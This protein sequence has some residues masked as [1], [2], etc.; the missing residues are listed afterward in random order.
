M[1]LA[2]TTQSPQ[3]LLFRLDTKVY[4]GLDGLGIATQ[5]GANNDVDN[6]Y[7]MFAM[8]LGTEQLTGL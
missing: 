7:K 5:N 4:F 8:V 6:V 2:T 1:K 3:A